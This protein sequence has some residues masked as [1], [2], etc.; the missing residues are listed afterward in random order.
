[1]SK[2]LA[3]FEE[4]FLKEIAGDEGLV[5]FTTKDF[6]ESV[7]SFPPI[8]FFGISCGERNVC[9]LKLCPI[10]HVS[11]KLGPSLRFAFQ[12]SARS[13]STFGAIRLNVS[14]EYNTDVMKE[15]LTELLR[16]ENVNATAISEGEKICWGQI[17][18][19]TQFLLLRGSQ[20]EVDK[21]ISAI[22]WPSD[23]K[24]YVSNFSNL[25]S[26]DSRCDC[27]FITDRKSYLEVRAVVSM[28]VDGERMVQTLR[29]R[30]EF[31]Y[32]TKQ[33]GQ[34]LQNFENIKAYILNR[35]VNC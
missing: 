1:M 11:I 7:H 25:T 33:K 13:E 27:N 35:F 9:V 8:R 5:I 32:I 10:S 29:A 21:T 19:A 26:V 23:Y 2:L 3:L 16:A 31:T 17:V 12:N 14:G 15:S 30:Y 6:A 18:N 24:T 28:L 34:L 22:S 4:I 20:S